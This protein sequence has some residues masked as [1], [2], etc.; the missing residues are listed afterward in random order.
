MVV[1][2]A[3]LWQDFLESMVPIYFLMGK[4]NL[5]PTPIHGTRKQTLF[6]LRAQ[7]ELAFPLVEIKK[8]AFGLTLILLMTTFKPSLLL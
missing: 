7:Q 8:N 1:L 5:F 3:H 2:V 4:I 6:I